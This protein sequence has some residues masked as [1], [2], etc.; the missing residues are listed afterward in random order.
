MKIVKALPALSLLVGGLGLADYSTSAADI[1]ADEGA[2]SNVV[3]QAQESDTAERVKKI[4]AEHL[5]VE[6]SKVTGNA[7]F[8]H[9]LGA[10]SLDLVELTM[11]F[12]EEFSLEIPDDACGQIV[13]VRDAINYI[14][15]H[16]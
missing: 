16:K 1:A 8:V 11:A 13:T 10:D 3:Q 5:G 7:S 15:T 14:E 4:V 9:D 6:E 12:E 2:F